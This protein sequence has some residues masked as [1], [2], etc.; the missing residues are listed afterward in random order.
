MSTG[1]KWRCTLL[2]NS[3]DETAAT[4]QRL[5][6]TSDED[7][8]CT[9]RVRIT[10]RLEEDTN[11]RKRC[12]S[13]RNGLLITLV[14]SSL[15]IRQRAANRT[16]RARWSM[17]RLRVIMHYQCL[18][19]TKTRRGTGSSPLPP[20][21]RGRRRRPA[22]AYADCQPHV[23][24]SSRSSTTFWRQNRCCRTWEPPYV[25]PGAPNITFPE[26]WPAIFLTNASSL[27][28]FDFER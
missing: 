6:I 24:E 28:C 17:R 2:S 5:L 4:L 7:N 23:L 25:I 10:T 16:D 12:T 15:S 19:M 11:R 22:T 9:I 26:A 3:D 20:R 21:R 8:S 18:N 1:N 13:N 14:N 27:Y